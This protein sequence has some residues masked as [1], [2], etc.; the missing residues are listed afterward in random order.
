MTTQGMIDGYLVY[1]QGEFEDRLTVGDRIKAY[2]LAQHHANIKGVN[3][4]VKK[5]GAT[6]YRIFKPSKDK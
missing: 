5:Q 6:S 1:P 2:R 3:Y 4:I